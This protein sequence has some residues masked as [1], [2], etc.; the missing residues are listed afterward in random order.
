[1]RAILSPGGHSVAGA[2]FGDRIDFC[3][4]SQVVFVDGNFVATAIF[5]A[6][7]ISGDKI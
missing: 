2:V 7:R 4:E 5:V 1:L 3:R 6:D